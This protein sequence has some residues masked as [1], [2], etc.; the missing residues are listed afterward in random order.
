MKTINRF[1]IL[2]A[3]LFFIQ[4][5]GRAI[6][7]T[8]GSGANTFDIDFVTIGNP[9][10]AADTTGFPYVAGSVSYNYR[11]GTY[12]ISRD[13]ITKAN[14]L[15][16]LLI[17]LDD[18]TLYGGNGANRPAGVSW[19]E[20]ARFVNW[21][22]TSTGCVPAYKFRLQVGDPGYSVFGQNL[23]WSPSDAGYDPKNLYRNRLAR[24]FLPSVDEWYKAA[25]YDPT[26]GNYFDYP[27]GSD[28]VPTSVAS[29]TA[30]GT[31]VYVD[32]D[33]Q[34]PEVAPADVTQAGGLS[35]YG[36][37]A[38]GGN[39]W[40]WQETDFDLANG[41]GD[42]NRFMRGGAY[43]INS[44]YMSSFSGERLSPFNEWVG[45]RVASMNVPEP[46]AICAAGLAITTW[47]CRRARDVRTWR[48]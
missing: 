28:T 36:T 35:P 30:P 4:P 8:F 32:L 40:E 48:A 9:G 24:Y 44:E 13:A 23:T 21:L 2:L 45:F 11:I 39:A 16:N 31:A 46:S 42:G 10:N 38:Q 37:M 14:N 43:W 15:G 47:L 34:R 25:Y 17:S 5:S 6:G 19:Y 29:G 1:A 20:A 33:H 7:D 26:S 41:T 22:N 18:L 3:A 12:E 27:T